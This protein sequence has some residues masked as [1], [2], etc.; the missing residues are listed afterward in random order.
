[1]NL[2]CGWRTFP[3]GD[4]FQDPDEGVAAIRHAGIEPLFL[5][6]QLPES[7]HLLVAQFRDT[8]VDVVLMACWR[9]GFRQIVLVDPGQ[10]FFQG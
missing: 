6:P 10:Q 7:C 9:I 4:V 3:F 2:G 5:L 8:P 1:L